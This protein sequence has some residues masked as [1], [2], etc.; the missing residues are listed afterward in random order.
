MLFR[1]KSD[2]RLRLTELMRLREAY[3]PEPPT[4]ADA[5]DLE[6]AK[7]RCHACNAKKLCD[8]ALAAGNKNAFGLF[9]P[10]CH[11]IQHVR[12]GS[13]TFG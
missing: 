9:C 1:K 13:L 12:G 6:A 3:L 4:T 5:R 2:A 7:T 8:E 11:Y 10:N